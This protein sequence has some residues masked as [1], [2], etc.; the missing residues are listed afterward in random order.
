MQEATRKK[1][2]TIGEHVAHKD[3]SLYFVSEKM[4]LFN[5]HLFSGISG[6][7]DRIYGADGG[8]A[9]R[10][11]EARLA[12]F[13][14]EF[15]PEEPDR[16]LGV[17]ATLMRPKAL[18]L[19]PDL[20]PLKLE[21]LPDVVYSCNGFRA[22]WETS[23]VRKIKDFKS[24]L[25]IQL[26]DKIGA[27]KT[28]TMKMEEA[29]VNGDRVVEILLS[30]PQNREECVVAGH[31]K[32]V[33]M[34]SNK[35][36]GAPKWMQHFVKCFDKN[37]MEAPGI[38]VSVICSK[39]K[40]TRVFQELMF[41]SFPEIAGG[42][43]EEWQ[44]GTKE[45]QATDQ[46]GLPITVRRKAFF[47]KICIPLALHYV[48][49]GT[50]ALDRRAPENHWLTFEDFSFRQYDPCELCQCRDGH[51][52]FHRLEKQNGSAE[53]ILLCPH[54]GT[55]PQCGL[56]QAA[57]L[58]GGH[59]DECRRSKPT[60]EDCGRMGIPAEHKP[61]DLIRCV[62]YQAKS[63]EEYQAKRH[64]QASV[65]KAFETL[66]ARAISTKGRDFQPYLASRRA[67]AKSKAHLNGFYRIHEELGD[68][69]DTLRA[70]APGTQLLPLFK[71]GGNE[72]LREEV[73]KGGA[74]SPWAKG[75]LLLD[76]KGKVIQG[77]EIAK[78][79][80][81]SNRSWDTYYKN[82]LFRVSD[83][84]APRGR[85]ASGRQ[86]L[87]PSCGKK[88]PIWGGLRVTSINF[89]NFLMNKCIRSNTW[90]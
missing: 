23:S 72:G 88:P 40:D 68:F 36:Q 62:S 70:M 67:A 9:Y 39:S 42:Q 56:G 74:E 33:I 18:E 6:E 30:L 41:R 49:T 60:C 26:R 78:L 29:A 48:G 61:M 20:K 47:T 3:Y 35:M 89:V 13:L 8:M 50:V 71:E 57:F 16:L 44:M 58:Y 55:C 15:N 31:A 52:A 17:A 59:I 82:L 38:Y 69:Q 79:G 87:N 66:L 2:I 73:R 10:M 28:L 25:R 80:Q 22:I 85:E 34:Y 54:K 45:V 37:G 43:L 53:D 4:T 63:N 11:E 1:V 84:I 24:G 81:L 65:N 7:W 90:P 77:M 32:Q 46:A 27:S 64:K 75:G 5:L 19:N 21:R 86:K 83:A 12:E 14:E 51:Q 76:R